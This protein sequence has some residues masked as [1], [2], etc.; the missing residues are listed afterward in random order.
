ML[1]SIK[2]YVDGLGRDA[3]SSVSPKIEGIEGYLPLRVGE[4]RRNP[5]TIALAKFFPTSSRVRSGFGGLSCRRSGRSESRPSMIADCA[6]FKIKKKFF[7]ALQ[8]RIPLFKRAAYIDGRRGG[9]TDREK[10]TDL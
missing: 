6:F 9:R 3:L 8:V 1:S 2:F 7:L 10:G 4:V 5:A